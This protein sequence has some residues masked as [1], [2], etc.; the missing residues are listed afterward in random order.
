MDQPK[1]PTFSV[2]PIMVSS[3]AIWATLPRYEPDFGLPK[4]EYGHRPDR[5]TFCWACPICGGGTA[6]D[7]D[8]KEH[9]YNVHLIHWPHSCTRCGARFRTAQEKMEHEDAVHRPST[10]LPSDSSDEETVYDSA[11]PRLESEVVEE[12]HGTRAINVNDQELTRSSWKRTG[13]PQP[14]HADDFA[15]IYGFVKII[16]G[17][18]DYHWQRARVLL[19][20]RKR[21]RKFLAI[22]VHGTDNLQMEHDILKLIKNRCPKIVRYEDFSVGFIDNRIMARLAMEWFPNGS[23]RDILDDLEGLGKSMSEQDVWRLTLDV[24]QALKFLQTGESDVS[25]SVKGW[26]PIVHYDLKPENIMRYEGGWKLIDFGLAQVLDEA[27]SNINFG[28][29]TGGT[30]FY[31]APEWPMIV[32]TKADVWALGVIIHLI[33]SGEHPRDQRPYSTEEIADMNFEQWASLP[34]KWHNINQLEL[35]TSN[36]SNPVIGPK[37]G[38]YSWLLYQMMKWMLQP[39]PVE[40]PTSTDMNRAVL[41]HYGELSRR[42]TISGRLFNYEVAYY[43]RELYDLMKTNPNLGVLRLFQRESYP[44]LSLRPGL[45]QHPYSENR[46]QMGNSQHGSPVMGNDQSGHTPVDPTLQV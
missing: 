32:G 9:I 43:G 23:L 25:S 10:V 15:I 6:T 3:Y 40:R 18:Y 7:F 5:P 31:I 4:A 22:K 27:E 39:H 37:S 38:S 21:D 8:M 46:L 33:C 14:H 35:L 28:P 26:C 16:R 36:H 20:E 34:V 30:M 12:V 19:V 1:G 17:N 45:G 44:N 41:H 42:C 11:P 13:A 24:S 2:T 29:H